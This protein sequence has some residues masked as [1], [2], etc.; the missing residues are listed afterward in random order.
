MEVADAFRGKHVVI[1]GHTG[2][3]GSWLALALH[4]L[5]ARLY[6]LSLPPPTSPSHFEVSSIGSLFEESAIGDVRA[7][8]LVESTL[9]RAQ[10]VIVFHLAAQALVRESYREPL[11]TFD[12]NVVGTASVLDAV[13]RRSPH[14][15]VVVVTSDKCYEEANLDRGYREDDPLGGH[16][17]YSA[18][19][20]AAELVA[21]SFRRSFNLRIATARAGNVIGGG[22]WAHDR[23][24]VDA[25]RAL[26]DGDP[27]P[28]RNP[29]AVRPFQHVLEPVSGYLRLAAALMNDAKYASAWNFGPDPGSE[30]TVRDLVER[31][32]NIYGSGSW[33]DRSNPGAVHEA[34]QLVL[35]ASHARELGWKPRWSLDQAL[36]RAVGWYRA[37]KRGAPMRERSLDDL[38]AYGAP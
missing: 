13:R 12:T 32:I 19:K 29:N 16:D 38:S 24:V 3:K 11:E 2:F 37:A 14:S 34:R 21:A 6:G 20:A 28:V 5:G 18:S 35:D 22:D 17:P 15:A 23:I 1:T 36:E 26:L 4:K 8:R 7:R 25:M 31:M 10:P 27:I 33:V 9:D 30:T